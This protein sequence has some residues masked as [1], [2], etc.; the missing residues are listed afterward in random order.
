MTQDKL[1]PK[2]SGRFK[3]M[4]MET[5]SVQQLQQQFCMGFNQAVRFMEY[6]STH[7]MLEETITLTVSRQFKSFTSQFQFLGINPDIHTLSDLR[8]ARLSRQEMIESS[9]A[10]FDQLR[11][12]ERIK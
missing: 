8:E 2:Y 7:Q 4:E 3:V 1:S 10:Y 5:V 6:L 12:G 9:K 11:M